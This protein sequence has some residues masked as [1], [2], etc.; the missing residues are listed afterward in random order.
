MTW[1]WSCERSGCAGV[2]DP[3]GLVCPAL[4]WQANRLPAPATTIWKRAPPF[5]SLRS[6][7][8]GMEVIGTISLESGPSGPVYG[9]TCAAGNP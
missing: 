2:A 7:A 5:W 4:P 9:L 3:L 1:K 8:G 6:S